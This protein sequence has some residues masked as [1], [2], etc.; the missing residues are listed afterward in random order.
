MVEK[1]EANE[2]KFYQTHEITLD[3]AVEAAK[4]F[5]EQQGVPH[6]KDFQVLAVDANRNVVVLKRELSVEEVEKIRGKQ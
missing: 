4:I 1:E 3:Y 5:L 6:A 2:Q